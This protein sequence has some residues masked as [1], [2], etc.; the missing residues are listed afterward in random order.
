GTPPAQPPDG[1]SGLEP[2]IRGATTIREQLAKHRELASC[3]SCHAKIDPLGFA[4]ESFDV[5]GS[6]RENY[7]SVGNGNTVVVDGKRTRYS[8]G[9]A[10]TSADVLQ[11]GRG[12]ADI[13]E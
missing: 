9:P 1:V 13:D 12:F 10:I 8:I 11:D 5:I 2:D 6:W 4:L 3:R 7:R